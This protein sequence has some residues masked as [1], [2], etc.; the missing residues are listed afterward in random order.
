MTTRLKESVGEILRYT[1]NS[2]QLQTIGSGFRFQRGSWHVQNLKTTAANVS[3]QALP[4]VRCGVRCRPL[5]YV[6][7]TAAW[8]EGPDSGLPRQAVS[9]FPSLPSPW[10]GLDS[11]PSMRKEHSCIQVQF[12][13]NLTDLKRSSRRLLTRLSDESE[14]GGD[15]VVFNAAGDGLEIVAIS[16]S[17]GLTA[18]VSNAGVA[19]MPYP[20]F[21]G[22]IRTFSTYHTRK[23]M[24][25]FSAGQLTV[26]G[27]VFRH[28]Q[29]SVGWPG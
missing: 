17:E 24:F 18:V 11:R 29:I 23:L 9:R 15:F 8:R 7:Y 22:I 16:T 21:R 20:V 28:P 25:T 10:N 6:V 19:R 12:T 1:S 27:T 2:L 26:N 4:G 3:L 13:V 14:A 5:R